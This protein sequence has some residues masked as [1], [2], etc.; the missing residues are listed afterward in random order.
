MHTPRIRRTLIA[1]TALLALCGSGA[2]L[3]GAASAATPDGWVKVN[4]CT[5][6]G[7]LTISPLLTA[8]STPTTGS[9]TG[10][11]TGCT[12]TGGVPSTTTGTVTVTSLTGTASTSLI[13]LTGTYTVTWPASQGLSPSSGT[14]TVYQSGKSLSASGNI[15]GGAYAAGY[16]AGTATVTKTANKPKLHITQESF[17]GT[18]AAE[19]NFG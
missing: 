19:E 18:V 12:T 1:S 11:L 10:T 7:K 2:A 5:L 14:F 13:D 3:A 16:M 8:T 6:A 15:T 4:A 17:I 9:L